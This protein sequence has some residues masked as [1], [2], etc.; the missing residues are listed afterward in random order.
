MK[1]LPKT[2]PVWLAADPIAK[3]E[4]LHILPLLESVGANGLDHGAVY[5]YCV[6]YSLYVRATQE[7][8]GQP[9]VIEAPNGVKQKNPLL[10]IAR[11]AQEKLNRAS[12]E[13]LITPGARKR[14]NIEMGSGEDEDNFFEDVEA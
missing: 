6:T 4:Y 14:L 10:C 11:D 1:T 3:A 8:Q 5:S 7:M 9:L 2:P 12:K 13:L